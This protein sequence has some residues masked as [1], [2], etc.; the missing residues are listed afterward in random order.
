MMLLFVWLI[1][2]AVYSRFADDEEVEMVQGLDTVSLWCLL[3][4]TGM[5]WVV[6]VM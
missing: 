2:V 3:G 6:L 1:A 5:L 4:F